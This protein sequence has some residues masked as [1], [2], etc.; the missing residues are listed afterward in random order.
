M[1]A[2]IIEE[3]AKGLC[4][5]VVLVLC[6]AVFN[7]LSQALLVGMW[8]GFFLHLVA[9]VLFLVT[10]IVILRRPVL[11]AEVATMFMAMFFLVS[12]L[13]QL[14]GSLVLREPDWGWQA[15]NGIITLLMGIVVLAQWPAS[16]LWLI[17]LFVES[18]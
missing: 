9:A 17:G 13:F 15:L 7:L 11:G 16:G 2:P 8:A 10:G 5:V 3:S 14:V 18:I 1:T 12:G 4:A 6:G